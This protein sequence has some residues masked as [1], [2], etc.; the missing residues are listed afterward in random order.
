MNTKEHG[1]FSPPTINSQPSTKSDKSHTAP[2]SR[3]GPREIPPP[4]AK[5]ADTPGFPGRVW[6]IDPR[7][8]AC[9]DYLPFHQ[10][11]FTA[12]ANPAHFW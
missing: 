10:T 1:F 9:L 4:Q 8:C 3:A 12:A 2:N 6:R 7:G 5:K 11:G